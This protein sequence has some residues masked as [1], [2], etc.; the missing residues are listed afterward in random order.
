VFHCTFSGTET[1]SPFEI[2]SGNLHAVNGK[3]AGKW[4][5]GSTVAD[6]M[7]G[8]VRDPG[9][10][11]MIYLPD[12]LAPDGFNI[13]WSADTNP[14]DDSNMGDS[15][16]MTYPGHAGWTPLN[17]DYADHIIDSFGS[18]GI[19]ATDTAPKASLLGISED[20]MSGAL[21]IGWKTEE[22]A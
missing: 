10:Q 11:P 14:G 19:S 21:R 5:Y 18:L 9:V 17:T 4:W 22:A 8:R 1:F 15:G 2:T 6:S 3:S 16:P 12:G 7:A 20:P 13:S